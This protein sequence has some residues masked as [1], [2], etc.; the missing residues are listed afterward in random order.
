[1][2]TPPRTNLDELIDLALGKAREYEYALSPSSEH[3]LRRYA[4]TL[5]PRLNDDGFALLLEHYISDKHLK[6]LS[7]EDAPNQ[8]I[9]GIQK[10]SLTPNKEFVLFDNRKYLSN[11]YLVNAVASQKIILPDADL[12]GANLERSDLRI[13]NL[14]GADMTDAALRDAIL[15]AN[16]VQEYQDTIFP[17]SV[18]EARWNIGWDIPAHKDF[19]V[20]WFVA[21]PNGD[22]VE[23]FIKIP[24]KERGRRFSEAVI[25]E[26]AVQ[27]MRAK[28]IYEK[29]AEL[30]RGV[31]TLK[32]AY[33]ME[34]AWMHMTD[35]QKERASLPPCLRERGFELSPSMQDILS[36]GPGWV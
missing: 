15:Y 29:A 10:G 3:M 13:V 20:P 4:R 6:R 21:A 5:D 12:R 36:V 28:R 16:Q 2:D 17:L 35:A 33:Q 27:A 19:S 11:A 31:V 26:D 34:H 1:M 23:A 30:N 24:P 32:Q 18:E 14:Q 7:P 22:L 25:T 8:R 9:M